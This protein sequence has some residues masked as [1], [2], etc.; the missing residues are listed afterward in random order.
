MK[1]FGAC[2]K[3]IVTKMKNIALE[4]ATSKFVVL[5]LLEESIDDGHG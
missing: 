3:E 2:I 4:C 5:L 1:I